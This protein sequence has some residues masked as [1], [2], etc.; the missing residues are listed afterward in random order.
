MT[1][2]AA[3]TSVP[4]DRTRAEIERLLDANG[5]TAFGYMTQQGQAVVVFEIGRRRVLMALPLPDREDREFSYTPSGRQRRAPAEA[6][7]LYDQAVRARWRAL[8]LIIKAKLEAVAA[9]IT[10]I[11]REFLADIALPSGQT[12]GQWAGPAL[13]TVYAGGQMPALLPG[14]AS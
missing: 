11:E 8:L 7:R 3:Q 1:R 6:T 4:A 13:E 2:Y 9:G 10:T 5:G 14:Q 12:V